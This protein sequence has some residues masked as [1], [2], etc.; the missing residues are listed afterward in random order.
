MN[1]ISGV[2]LFRDCALFSL[3]LLVLLATMLLLAQ[4]VPNRYNLYDCWNCCS[5]IYF[6]GYVGWPLTQLYLIIRRFTIIFWSGLLDFAWL[7]YRLLAK[8]TSADW[9][10]LF[11][12]GPFFGYFPRC[13]GLSQQQNIF[14]GAWSTS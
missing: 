11:I 8:A 14:E 3:F 13:S 7:S 5:E 4:Q 12:S 6:A 10:L 9:Y 2:S 1:N